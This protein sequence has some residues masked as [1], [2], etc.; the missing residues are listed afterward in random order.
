MQFEQLNQQSYGA[1]VER[2]TWEADANDVFPH[3]V[4]RK[5]R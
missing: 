5:L 1:T 2:W 3:E 4:E